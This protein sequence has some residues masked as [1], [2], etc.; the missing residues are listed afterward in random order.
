L[1]LIGAREEKKYTRAVAQAI[2]SPRSIH[3]L[4][5]TLN[6][7]EL[8]G[9]IKHAAFFISNDSGP[10]H[11][12]AALQKPVIGFYGPETPK[13]FGPLCDERLIFY[14]GLPCSPCMSVDN[15]KT[16]NCTNHRRCMLDLT[17]S[18]VISRLQYFI[19]ERELLPRRAY[20]LPRQKS[21]AE[22]RRKHREQPNYF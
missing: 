9:L 17:E 1:V 15:A 21:P 13:R 10:M 11:L 5:G 4:S 14:L 8:A 2:D 20:Q 3:D 19:D 7:I 16:V 18:M 22:I 6:L 12:A